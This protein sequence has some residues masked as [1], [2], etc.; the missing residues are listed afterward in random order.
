MDNQPLTPPGYD[1]SSFPVSGSLQGKS[2]RPSPIM[3]ILVV[4]FGLTTLI[5]GSLALMFSSQASTATKT[6]KAKTAAAAT[7]AREE[8]KKADDEAN[9]KANNSPFR[10]Y[11]APEEFGSFVVNFP[12]TWSSWV[13]QERSGT[14]VSL[15][16][17]P[18]FVR[19]TNGQDELM[20]TR[21]VLLERTK[22]SFMSQYQGLLKSGKLKQADIKV[23]GLSAIDVTGTFTGSKTVR[24]VVVP[25]RDKVLV[26]TTES[27]KYSTEFNEILAQAKIIP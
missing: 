18:D 14:Q 25:I 15:I 27:T 8:Q 9:T 6:L 22:D 4:V 19:R 21:V 3:L 20:A 2:G 7:V 5:F 12:K 26:F 24:Q 11:V 13:D 1:P 23:S 10:A 17:N 16:L